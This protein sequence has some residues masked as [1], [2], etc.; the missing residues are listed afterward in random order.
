MITHK[1]IALF[2]A[3]L[4]ALLSSG[5]FM[6]DARSAFL[7]DRQKQDAADKD[8]DDQA[9]ASSGR[10]RVNE[11]SL[12]AASYT[13]EDSMRRDLAKLREHEE[14]QAR[15]LKELQNELSDG[16]Q[17]MAQEEERL[18]EIRDRIERY[19]NAMGGVSQSG[20]SSLAYARQRQS[21]AAGRGYGDS[22]ASENENDYFANR[23]VPANLARTPSQNT[24]YGDPLQEEVLFSSGGPAAADNAGNQYS[25]F[26][27]N[28]FAGAPRIRSGRTNP[29]L[30]RKVQEREEQEARELERALAEANEN[31]LMVWNPND[32]SQP[33]PPGVLA[34]Q[35]QKQQEMI[36]SRPQYNDAGANKLAAAP[37]AG[38]RAPQADTPAF[39]DNP[40]GNYTADVF[41]PDLLF[42]R[43]S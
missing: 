33:V 35:P 3:F 34:G 2:L 21:A 13:P 42:G 23:K 27:P 19:E 4:L 39:D 31:E 11:D 5:C 30:M 10:G 26:N 37:A 22:F 6:S 28:K 41:S 32:P 24:D 25:D 18:A 43:G 12:D 40:Y 7:R 1:I 20:G 14:K 17:I 38:K 15:L 29:D 16:R 8:S 9:S 36:V